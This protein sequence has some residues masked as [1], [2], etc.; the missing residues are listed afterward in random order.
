M[1]LNGSSSLALA[2]GSGLF[3]AF[4]TTY[5]S[6]DAGFFARTLEAT[7]SNVKRLVVF[8]FNLRHSESPE[9]V[10]KLDFLPARIRDPWQE[11]RIFY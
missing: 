8:Y 6:Q 10:R 7:Q 2:N 5:F 11:G 3:I 1:T 4:T 9:S